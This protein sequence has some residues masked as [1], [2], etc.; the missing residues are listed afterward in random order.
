QTRRA[1]RAGR[2]DPR[3]AAPGGEPA[4]GAVRLRRPGRGPGRAQG[5][6]RRRRRPPDP[7]RAAAAAGADPP[8]GQGAE[9]PAAAARR[10]GA[11]L[12]GRLPSRRRLHPTRPGQ[13]RTRPGR[14]RPHPDRPGVRLP[15]LPAVTGS[16][17]RRRRGLFSLRLRLV[18]AL[19]V[20]A[21]VSTLLAS[22]IGYVL[23]H[24]ALLQQAQDTALEQVRQV[25]THQ[26]PPVLV[27]PALDPGSVPQQPLEELAL[28]LRRRTQGQALVLVEDTV[29]VSSG[30]RL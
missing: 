15:L 23:F 28:E 8:P 30:L 12:P 13:G 7:D 4:A 2:P 9:P 14:P 6:P 11:R 5:H 18:G 19:T 20:M 10:V 21:L 17:P 27:N 25:L 24:R 16:A 29:R 3:G 1:A 22:G 26:V